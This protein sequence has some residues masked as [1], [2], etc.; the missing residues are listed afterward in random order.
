[1][2]INTHQP[3]TNTVSDRVIHVSLEQ[4]FKNLPYISNVYRGLVQG[5][6]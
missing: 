4:K 1:M 3:Y 5:T 2:S 6:A